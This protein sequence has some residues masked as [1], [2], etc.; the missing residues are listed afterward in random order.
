MYSML[1]YY[2]PA[3]YFWDTHIPTPNKGFI[4]TGIIK[5]KNE[6]FTLKPHIHKNSDF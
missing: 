1:K 5:N 4:Y 2:G 3:K 6:A